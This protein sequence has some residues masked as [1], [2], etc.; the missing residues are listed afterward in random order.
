MGASVRERRLL[1]HDLRN[2]IARD[3]LSLVY[4]PQKEINTGEI[5]GF[6]ALLRWKHPSR[7]DVPPDEFIPIA[8]DTGAILQIGEW[9]LRAA[10]R[11]AATWTKPL[12]MAVNVSAVQVHNADFAHMVHEILFETGFDK[13]DN[14]RIGFYQQHREPG[15]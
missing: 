9:V 11:E 8:E 2:A 13:F 12:T 4:Q 5:I 7:G 3:E 14:R 6:E 1:E 10:C 15:R